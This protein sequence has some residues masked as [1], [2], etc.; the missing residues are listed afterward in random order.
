M[1]LLEDL[2]ED[3]HYTLKLGATDFGEDERPAPGGWG[4]L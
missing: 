1:V 2:V 3:V 4:D